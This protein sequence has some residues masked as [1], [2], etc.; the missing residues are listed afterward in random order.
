MGMGS[1]QE[2]IAMAATSPPSAMTDAT[3]RSMPPMIRTSVMPT[4]PMPMSE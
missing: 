3:D 2:V 1:P 4:A